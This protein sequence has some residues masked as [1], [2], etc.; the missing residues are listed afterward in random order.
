MADLNGLPPQ[1]LRAAMKTG[2]A[3]WGEWGGARDHELYVLPSN[4]EPRR[5]RK[6]HCG[7]GKRGTH[8]VFANGVCLSSGCEF[9]CHRWAREM[10][11][12]R[13]NAAPRKP[14]SK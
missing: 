3:G 13:A 11:A 5:R 8:S 1:A 14:A 10:N 4:H 9:E 12:R 2:T 6:C 7:C